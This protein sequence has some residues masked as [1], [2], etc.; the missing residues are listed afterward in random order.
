MAAIAIHVPNGFKY[1]LPC[2]DNAGIGSKEY[3]GT[4]F[5]S[6]KIDFLPALKYLPPALFYFQSLKRHTRSRNGNSLYCFK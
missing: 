6:G 3:K 2:E 1:L 4:V 5:K